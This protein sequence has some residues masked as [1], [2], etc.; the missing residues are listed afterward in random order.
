MPQPVTSVTGFAMTKYYCLVLSLY[1]GARRGVA[2][3][4]V[5]CLVL[6]L[7]S[8]LRRSS[9]RQQACMIANSMY[10]NAATTVIARPRK[11][12]WQSVLPSPCVSLEGKDG[13]CGLP[14]PVTSVTGFAMTH[15]C[16]LVLNLYAGGRRGDTMSRICCLVLSLYAVARCG[17]TVL[18]FHSWCFAFRVK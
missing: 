10:P 7:L 15:F 9:L 8:V 13:S 17:D 18:H 2:M 14:Q 11:G 16:C 6:C 12:S 5:H 3:L 4:R 1:A